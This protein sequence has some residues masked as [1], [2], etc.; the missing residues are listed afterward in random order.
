ML[1]IDISGLSSAQSCNMLAT[2][3]LISSNLLVHIS[4]TLMGCS[5]NGSPEYFLFCPAWAWS[6]KSHAFWIIEKCSLNC[7]Y[8]DDIVCKNFFTTAFSIIQPRYINYSGNHT[9]LNERNKRTE[10]CKKNPGK[11]G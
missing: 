7:G 10:V 4:A 9:Y 2:T 5:I 6:A 11:P 1:A 3:K 8:F